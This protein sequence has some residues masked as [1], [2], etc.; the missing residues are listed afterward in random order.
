MITFEVRNGKIISHLPLDDGLYSGSLIKKGNYKT[1]YECVRYFFFLIH[2]YSD[3]TGYTVAESRYFLQK[4]MLDQL[5]N[6]H[7]VNAEKQHLEDFSTK[8]L[9]SEGFILL[10]DNMRTWLNDEFGLQV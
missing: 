10:I 6:E 4:I 5:S 3:Y 8:D 2:Q 1:H 9:T 7:F